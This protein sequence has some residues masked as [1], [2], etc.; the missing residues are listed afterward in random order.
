MMYVTD[1]RTAEC[2]RV[3]VRE[4]AEALREQCNEQVCLALDAERTKGGEIHF[5]WIDYS[6]L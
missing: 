1:C 4:L 5:V 2:F 6:A 3:S